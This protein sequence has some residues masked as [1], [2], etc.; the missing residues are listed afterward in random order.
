MQDEAFRQRQRP[1]G[2]HVDIF[3]LAAGG[4]DRIGGLSTS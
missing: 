3:A 2:D 4:C 1:Q